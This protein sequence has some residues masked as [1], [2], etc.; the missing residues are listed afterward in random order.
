M[1]VI[2]RLAVLSLIGIIMAMCAYGFVAFIH[3]PFP[4]TFNITAETERIEFFAKNEPDSRWVLYKV[5]VRENYSDSTHTFTGSFQLAGGV[6]VLIERIALGPLWIHIEAEREG[7]SAGT[8][9]VADDPVGP[10][11]RTLEFIISDL[12]S[13]ALAGET[14]VL[15]ITDILGDVYTGRSIG[16]DTE[17][18]T[19]LL[20]SGE[21]TMLDRSLF[22]RSVYK[23]GSETLQ[24]GDQFTIED[25]E[26]STFGF[27]VADERP[28]LNVAYRVVGRNAYVRRPGGITVPISASLLNRF[29]H[30][31]LFQGIALLF[32]ML[33][34]IV[35][36]LSFAMDSWTFWTQAKQ[37]GKQDKDPAL[38]KTV[39]TGKNLPFTVLLFCLLTPSAALAQEV[40]IRVGEQRGQGVLRP[41]GE[42]Y[43]VLTPHH[44][45]KQALGSIE[46]IGPYG[47]RAKGTLQQ[48]FEPDLA[49]LRIEEGS[50]DCRSWSVPADFDEA[51]GR[52]ASGHL[53]IREHD[54]SLSLMP[55]TFRNINARYIRVKPTDASDT[56]EKDMSGASLIINGSL[57]GFLLSIDGK[58]AGTVYQ[59]DDIIRL[60]D[61]IFGTSSVSTDTLSAESPSPRRIESKGFIFDLQACKKSGT[62]VVCR[63]LVTNQD[64]DRQL[65]LYSGTRIIDQAGKEYYAKHLALGAR[66]T[67]NTLVAGIPLEMTIT[68]GILQIDQARLLEVRLS[69]SRPF[70]IQYRD[71]PFTK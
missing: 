16:I 23:A 42:E 59:I 49:I 35:T 66:G 50:L 4:T 15:P 10:A 20:R 34:V 1:L 36:F 8:Y 22:G 6:N 63:F 9:Y 24:T 38:G 51:L 26:S 2:A 48:T 56:I 14:V 19:A 11:S 21:V 28:A 13:R 47:L 55:V 70:L 32:G 43:M 60:A 33:V 67:S 69:S 41:R 39:S 40:F 25:P 58:R 61:P 18:S 7:Q 27:I 30:D 12:S 5:Q 52:Q 45:V 54:G 46:I 64:Q 17:G 68:F 71:V 62:A 29:L 3:S 44:V 53:S 31:H 65:G 37:A 57:G